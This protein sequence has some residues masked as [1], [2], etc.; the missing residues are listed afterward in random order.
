MV[1]VHT[2]LRR[3][4]RL[5]GGAIR[6]VA[7]GD[8]RRADVV[9]DHLDFLTTFLHHHHTTEDRLLWPK[10]LERVPDELAPIV[11]LME[12]QHEQVD[13]FIGEIAQGLPRWRQHARAGDGNQLARLFDRLY[14]GLSEHL[15]AEEQRI[16]PIAARTVSLA[17]WSE[18]GEAGAR[19]TPKK[20]MPLVLGMLQYEGDPEVV[21][22]ILAEAP[23]LV[24]LIVPRLARRAFRRHALTI[25]GTVTP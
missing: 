17:E 10:L 5:A 18:I 13:A 9:A 8:T 22:E 1:C 6:G 2:F 14:A 16:L 3:E 19:G 15:D 24:R 25:H 11:R 7:A 21:A 4:Y 12:A 20:D 23:R